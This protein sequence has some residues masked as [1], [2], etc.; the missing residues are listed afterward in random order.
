MPKPQECNLS[1]EAV[2]DYA[3]YVRKLVDEQES[4]LRGKDLVDWLVKRLNGDAIIPSMWDSDNSGSLVVRAKD[5]FTIHLSPYT[6]PLHDVFT[7]AHELGH[8]F[9]H[10]DLEGKEEVRF[11]RL[12]SNKEEWQANRFAAAFL[13]PKNE[14][15]KQWNHYNKNIWMVGAHFGVSSSAANI[16]AQTLDLL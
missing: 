14:F 4:D 13:M 6:S 16:R 2:E 5:D 12:G 15:K 8:Y 9:L 11:N 7:I 1:L 10:C 3:D